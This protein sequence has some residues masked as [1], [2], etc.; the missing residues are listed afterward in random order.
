MVVSGKMQQAVEDQH[1]DLGRKRMSL[2]GC[3]TEG[4][5]DA[6]GQIAGYAFGAWA[7]RRERKHVRRF[8]FAAELP[9]ELA[10]GCVC[11]EQNGDLA[12]EAHG[13]LRGG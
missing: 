6:D 2:L 10:D 13:C 5:G 7:F 9:I 1:F 12:L 11:G 3:L 4:R 8:V